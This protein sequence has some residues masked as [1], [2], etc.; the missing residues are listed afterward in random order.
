MNTGT[1]FVIALPFGLVF[2]VAVAVFGLVDVARPVALA[3]LVLALVT[4]AT[5]KEGP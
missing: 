3:A 5:R 2:W 1:G 4:F